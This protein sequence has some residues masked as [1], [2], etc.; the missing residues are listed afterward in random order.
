MALDERQQTSTTGCANSACRHSK[1]SG[2]SPCQ[3]GAPTFRVLTSMIFTTT[4]SRL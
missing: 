1:S 3:R 2:R 4:S